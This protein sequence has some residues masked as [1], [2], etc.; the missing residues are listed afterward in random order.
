MMH[1]GRLAA[2]S[3][4]VR[5]LNRTCSQERESNPPGPAYETGEQPLL[6]PAMLPVSARGRDTPTGSTTP[7]LTGPH[8][9]RQRRASGYDPAYVGNNRWKDGIRT[10]ILQIH[11][12]MLCR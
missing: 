6:H 11:N 4:K 5:F 1:P 8:A 10:H 7:G 12:L 3:P 2:L 9:L